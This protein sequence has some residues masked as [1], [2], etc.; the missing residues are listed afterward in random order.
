MFTLPRYL[1]D[2]ERKYFT[3]VNINGKTHLLVKFPN[4]KKVSAEQM[5]NDTDNFKISTI[6]FDTLMSL[7][8]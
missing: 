2:E 3:P 7:A 6:D 1:T 5:T 4:G 8:K